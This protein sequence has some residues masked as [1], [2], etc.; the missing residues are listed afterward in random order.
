MPDSSPSG[1]LHIS[2]A[3]IPEMGVYDS[4]IQIPGLT[5]QISEVMPDAVHS[6][7]HVPVVTQAGCLIQGVDVREPELVQ[8][9]SP[10]TD[11]M[12][13]DIIGQISDLVVHPCLGLGEPDR[14]TVD[15]GNFLWFE[16][17]N[18]H[19][20]VR[21]IGAEVVKMDCLIRNKTKNISKVIRGCQQENPYILL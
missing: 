20:S 6:Q 4:S 1:S 21:D 8:I 10:F 15:D 2:P 11:D 18:C 17:S 14:E 12:G 9:F 5:Y 7:P 19:A 13:L 3:D 16:S